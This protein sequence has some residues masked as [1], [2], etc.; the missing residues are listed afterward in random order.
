MEAQQHLFK[1]SENAAHLREAVRVYE[2]KIRVLEFELSREKGLHDETDKVGCRML[3]VWC[4]VPSLDGYGSVGYPLS[5]T[6]KV[7]CPL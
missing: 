7:G 2:S 5:E 4:V 1:V 6:D 3:G